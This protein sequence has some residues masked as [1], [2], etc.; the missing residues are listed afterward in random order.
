V[1]VDTNCWTGHASLAGAG[2][3]KIGV[4]AGAGSLAVSKLGL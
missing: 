3:G 2:A 4:G 1:V